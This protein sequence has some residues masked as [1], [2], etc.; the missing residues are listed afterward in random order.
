MDKLDYSNKLEV[1]YFETRVM[2]VDREKETNFSKFI[3]AYASLPAN[4]AITIQSSKNY[5]AYADTTEVDD[6]VRNIVYSEEGVTANTLQLKV[7]PTVST[8]D[9]PE[10]ES[11]AVFLS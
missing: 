9:A 7:L 11:A 10:I 3:V 8:N 6:A 5:A 1:A 4:T 2:I